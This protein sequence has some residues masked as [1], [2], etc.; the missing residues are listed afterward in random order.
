MSLLDFVRQLIASGSAQGMELVVGVLTA[1]ATIE[2]FEK[3][4]G[5]KVLEKGLKDI[6]LV[7][8]AVLRR[9]PWQAAEQQQK[10]A[11][12]QEP[13]GLEAIEAEV[14]S[15]LDAPDPGLEAEIGPL[16]AKLAS[17]EQL[18]YKPQ[19]S[20]SIIPS[21]PDTTPQTIDRKA[22]LN[23]DSRNERLRQRRTQPH[24][25]TTSHSRSLP[26]PTEPIR[27]ARMG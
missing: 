3:K 11:A 4:L 6:Q 9:L 17:V 7:G 14:R 16:L 24:F 1:K 27:I 22:F 25:R 20:P 19:N 12:A 21:L 8:G 10:L 23:I 2:G 5:E 18:V 26:L 15:V 13:A